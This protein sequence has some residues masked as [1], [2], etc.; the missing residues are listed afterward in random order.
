M[1]I[2]HDRRMLTLDAEFYSFLL[3]SQI[4][5]GN[6]SGLKGSKSKPSQTP[7]MTLR[8]RIG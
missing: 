3:F 6:S 5:D 1:Y 7:S 4:P 2:K 8:T